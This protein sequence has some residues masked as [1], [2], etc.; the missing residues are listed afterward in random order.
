MEDQFLT[1]SSPSEGYYMERGSKFLAYAYPVETED[2]VQHFLQSVKKEHPKAR[3]YCT[4]FRLF[5]DGSLERSNDDGEPSGSAG[6]PILGQLI[7]NKLTNVCVVV[8]RYFGGT[9]LGIPGLIEAYKTSTANA[10][11]TAIIVERNVLTKVLI[12]LSYESF[13]SFLNYFKQHDIPVIEE[14]YGDRASFIICL[15]KSTAKQNLI[16][17]LHQLSQMDF[18]DLEH[19]MSYLGIE[20][21]VLKEDI[22]I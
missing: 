15:P 22:I 11:N 4:A 9:K 19:Y 5:P 2:D 16:E 12:T 17:I 6:R 1:L 21:E 8:V 18:E 3:H 13:P 7:K 14:S 20:V 10:I